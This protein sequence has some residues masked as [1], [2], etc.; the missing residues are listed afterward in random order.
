MRF[1]LL[2][3]AAVVLVLPG[4]VGAQVE[5]VWLTHRTT[6]ASKLTVNWTTKAPGDSKVRFGP[7]KEYDGE[8]R[9]PGSRTLHH[10]EV[11]L[12]KP[13]AAFHYAVSSG[14]QSSADHTFKGYPTDVLRVAVV[15]NWQGSPT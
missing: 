12:P 10:V 9:V 5:R 14:D 11:P 13:G 1:S 3:G 2:I 4:R 15:A 6:D 7:T 8:V